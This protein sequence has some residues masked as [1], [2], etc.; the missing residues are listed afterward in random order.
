LINQVCLGEILGENKN[1]ERRSVSCQKN[2][3]AIFALLAK[4]I[5]RILQ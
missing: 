5:K 3:I 2:K 1:I 4:K